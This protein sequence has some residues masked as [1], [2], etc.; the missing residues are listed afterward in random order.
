[1]LL[2]K[3]KELLD[4]LEKKK[5]E[6]AVSKKVLQAKRTSVSK[7]VSLREVPLQSNEIDIV[8]GPSKLGF[9]STT[10]SAIVAQDQNTPSN[11]TT[12]D[13]N[14]LEI[15]KKYKARFE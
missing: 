8:P 1:M 7:N 15:A 3:N 9:P 14:L 13:A 4:S 6:L 10:P 2:E 11:L 12:P 5:R